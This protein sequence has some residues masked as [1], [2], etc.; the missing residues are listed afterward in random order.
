ML[1][2]QTR[3]NTKQIMDELPDKRDDY[4]CNHEGNTSMLLYVISF[5]DVET[6]NN[7]Q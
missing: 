4:L 7:S 5:Q 6:I 3:K 2:L 1:N